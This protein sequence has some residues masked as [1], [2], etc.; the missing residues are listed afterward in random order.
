MVNF[1]YW[2]EVFDRYGIDSN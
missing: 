1:Y 2:R